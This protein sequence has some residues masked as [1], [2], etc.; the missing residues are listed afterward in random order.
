MEGVVRVIDQKNNMLERSNNVIQGESERIARLLEQLVDSWQEVILCAK[1]LNDLFQICFLLDKLKKIP[2]RNHE[3]I[4]LVHDNYAIG[5]STQELAYMMFIVDFLYGGTSELDDPTLKAIIGM[6]M[7][8][9]QSIA[10]LLET[11]LDD[12]LLFSINLYEDVIQELRI[13]HNV[14]EF[15]SVERIYQTIP[16][17]LLDVE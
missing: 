13:L 7:K 6:M 8:I 17:H 15:P 5:D 2:D 10:S 16:K 1:S 14:N 3:W 4:K 9:Q 11:G 12:N